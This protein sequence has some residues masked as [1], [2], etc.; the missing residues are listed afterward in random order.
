MITGQIKNQIDRIWDSF[1]G[2][3]S[4]INSITDLLNTDK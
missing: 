4:P 1:W 3:Q 2:K